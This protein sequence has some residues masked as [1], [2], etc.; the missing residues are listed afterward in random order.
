MASDS[1]TLRWAGGTWAPPPFLGTRPP[2]GIQ[3][4]GGCCRQR[5][6]PPTPTRKQ[7]PTLP[8]CRQPAH[9]RAD[10]RTHAHGHRRTPI[11]CSRACFQSQGSTRCTHWGTLGHIHAE[12]LPHGCSHYPRKPGFLQGGWVK[13]EQRCLLREPGSLDHSGR[14]WIIWGGGEEVG[15]SRQPGARIQVR[16]KVLT[17]SGEMGGAIPLQPQLR[18]G[19]SSSWCFGT[20]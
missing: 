5:P 9:S 7:P 18:P 17:P 12:F 14:D 20:R 6:S 10:T 1:S 19:N 16:C 2:A 13:S 4:Q 8:L 11:T 3:G 15:R